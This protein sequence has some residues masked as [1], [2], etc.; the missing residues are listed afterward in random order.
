M[1]NRVRETIKDAI[2][3]IQRNSGRIRPI[4]DSS[5]VVKDLGFTSLDVAEL[6]A[7]LEMELDVDPFSRGASL[8]DVRTYGDFCRVY[9][10]AARAKG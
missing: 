7:V 4:A 5:E 3:E 1:Q 2:E 9:E 8:L 6:V 10:E